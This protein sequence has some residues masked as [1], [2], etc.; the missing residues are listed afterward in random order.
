M[1]ELRVLVRGPPVGVHNIHGVGVHLGGFY[2]QNK[3]EV[4]EQRVL[5]VALRLCVLWY[6]SFEVRYYWGRNG[7]ADWKTGLKGVAFSYIAYLGNIGLDEFQ[8]VAFNRPTPLSQLVFNTSRR[9]SDPLE[10]E[11]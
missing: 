7:K 6:S 3:I 2:V 11:V 5:K 4:P 8:A 1:N 9:S 10:F